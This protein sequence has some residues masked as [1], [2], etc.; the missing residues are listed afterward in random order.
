[1]KKSKARAIETLI[2]IVK[3][4]PKRKEAWRELGLALQLGRGQTD[5]A[6]MEAYERMVKRLNAFKK[7]YERSAKIP[8]KG[9]A[10]QHGK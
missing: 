7:R 2:Y 10:N 6:L 9:K 3:E 8:T 5:Q 4:N 1:M